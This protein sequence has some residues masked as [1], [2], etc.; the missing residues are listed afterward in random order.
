MFQNNNNNNNNSQKSD[1]LFQLLEQNIKANMQ[2]TGTAI[3][4]P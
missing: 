2:L 1:I 4:A 3:V